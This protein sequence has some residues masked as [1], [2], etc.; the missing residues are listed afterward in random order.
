VSAP[1]VSILV[2]SHNGPAWLERS[3]RAVLDEAR[4]ECSCELIVADSASDAPTRDLLETWQD[5]ATVIWSQE[6]I[7]FARGC[8]M[9]ARRASGDRL[10]L[11]NPDAVVEPG[12]VD[13]LVEF[14]D[15][16]PGAGLVGGRTMRPDGGVDP[17]SCWGRPTLW[18]TFCFAV[19]LSTAFRRSLAFDP[20]S[21]GM[22][23]RDSVCE[24][25]I[26]TGCLLM[27]TRGTWDRLGGFDE[28]FFM[29][30]EDA[31]LSLRAAELGLRPAITPDAVVV[32]QAPQET[33]AH[34]GQG[35]PD[36]Q[37]LVATPRHGGRRPPPVRRGP[38][39]SRRA[40]QAQPR[41]VLAAARRRPVLDPRLAEQGAL[42][43]RRGRLASRH[44]PV[45]PRRSFMPR[46]TGGAPRSTVRVSGR[47]G[48]SAWF[49]DDRYLPAVS[50]TSAR[51]SPA[52]RLH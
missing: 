40:R 9:A 6:N 36:P 35:D 15:A 31:D 50:L 19:G 25:D 22:W 17:S 48:M 27:T 2:V 52:H 18:S 49:A 46:P 8:N 10:L 43:R 14:L 38:A 39:S 37:A 16:R 4:P 28:D 13:A 23:E 12:C 26:V 3:L 44:R 7:G 41:P 42:A 51:N 45:V 30:G 33:A 11:L 1:D 32:P 5:R 21:L 34:D 24:V 47:C 20:E 29:Y